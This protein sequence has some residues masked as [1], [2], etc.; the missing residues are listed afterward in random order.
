VADSDAGTLSSAA[1][2]SGLLSV[3]GDCTLLLASDCTLLLTFDG[4]LLAGEA[5]LTCVPSDR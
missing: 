3:S 2:S 5:W 1:G 4:A